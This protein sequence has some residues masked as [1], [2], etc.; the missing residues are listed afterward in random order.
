MKRK[1]FTV[2]LA[3]VFASSLFLASC[4]ESETKTK[5]S[6]KEVVKEEIKED[7]KEVA[8]TADY[9]KGK[10][11]YEKTCQ[12]CHQANG[13]GLATA[14]PPLA[15]SDYLSNK[16]AVVNAITKGLTGELT[17]NGVKFNTPMAPVVISDEEI[18]DVVNYVYNSWGNK[19]GT[20]T[21]DEV[22]A[23]KAKAK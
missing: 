9:S 8:I 3:T 7:V 20:I 22:K 19:N 2:A 18:V 11:V 23:A 15:G 16:D 5:D 12:A 21:L 14:F 17:V 4:G 10:A 13:K 1:I 6:T